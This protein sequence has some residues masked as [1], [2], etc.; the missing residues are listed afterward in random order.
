M[1]A[2]WVVLEAYAYEGAEVIGVRAAASDA[3][4]LAEE[5]AGEA[6]RWR[7]HLCSEEQAEGMVG[8]GSSSYRDFI[9]ERWEVR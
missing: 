8:S 6:L 7:R 5:R 2:V 4:A 9:V 1:S 3:Y